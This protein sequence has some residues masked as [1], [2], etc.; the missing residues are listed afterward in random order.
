MAGKL[1]PPTA[2]YVVIAPT[3]YDLT[4]TSIHGTYTDLDAAQEAA[5]ATGFRIIPSTVYHHQ[6]YVFVP[7]ATS[8]DSHTNFLSAVRL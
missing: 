4:T 5:S 8:V 2:V 1:T 6:A 7:D 3:T